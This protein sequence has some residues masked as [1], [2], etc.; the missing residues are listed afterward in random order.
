M[1]TNTLL[2]K[3]ALAIFCF[4]ALGVRAQSAS[5]P[6][7]SEL[8]LEAR[9]DAQF[10]DDNFGLNGKY[11]NFHMGGNLTDKFSYYVRQRFVANDGNV[12]FFDNTDFLYLNYKLNNN[13]QFRGGKDALAVGGFEYDAR[14]INVYMPA[15]YWDNFYC[16][17]LGASATWSS[18]DGHHK[19]MG[20]V[21]ASPYCYT[22]SPYTNG[23]ADRLSYNLLWMGSFEHVNTLWSV[24]A[25][26][27]ANAGVGHNVMGNIALGTQVVYPRWNGYLDVIFRTQEFLFDVLDF[28][29]VSRFNYDLGKGFTAFAKGGYERNEGA[30]DYLGVTF[31]PMDIMAIPSSDYCF[32]GLG[33]EYRPESCKDVRLHAYVAQFNRQYFN[34]TP[35]EKNFC[36]NF[37]LTWDMNF[38]KFANRK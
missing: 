6:F 1:K 25:F 12:K 26:S 22:G 38:L 21:A 17:Q 23:K 33:C 29:V 14:P 28:S 5:S 32:Y 11:L 34:N 4:A 24:N 31:L 2:T 35:D 7:F 36:F 9:A 16:F 20:Q 3:V 13:W 30:N 15:Y 19:L 10:T 37:G 27:Y 8:K 18:N